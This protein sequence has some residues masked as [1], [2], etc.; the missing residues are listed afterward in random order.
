MGAQQQ[1][2]AVRNLLARAHAAWKSQRFEGTK[3]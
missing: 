1:S 2:D 3:Q